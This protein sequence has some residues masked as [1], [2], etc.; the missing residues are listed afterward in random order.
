MTTGSLVE[1]IE[2][3]LAEVR[4]MDAPLAAKLDHVAACVRELSPAFAEAVDR[5]LDRL[6][7]SAAGTGAPK[8][9]DPMPDFLLP[10]ETGRLLGLDAILAEGPVAIVFNRGHWCPYCRINTDAIV[11]AQNLVADEGRRIVAIMPERQRYSRLLKAESHAGFPILTDTDNGY[12]LALGLVVWVSDE[13]RA[14]IAAAGWDIAAY[15]GNDAW[16]LP[17]PAT[18]VVGTDGRITERFVDPDYRKRMAVED[19]LAALREAR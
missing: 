2:T 17:I 6:R 4:V 7:A 12:A 8:P 1:K 19:L 18:F 16:M 9:G 14:M 15:Q 5:F 11:A 10:D 13:M 3:A